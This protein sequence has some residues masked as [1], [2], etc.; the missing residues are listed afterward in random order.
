MKYLK[1]I[2]KAKWIFIPPK[3]NKFVLVDGTYNP[4]LKYLK[5]KDFTI[6]HRR[7]EE[8]NF[9]ILLKCFFKFKF[10]S[11]DYCA[12]FIEY[13]SPKLIL[14]GFDYHTIFYKLSKRTGV[15]TLMLQKGKRSESE[16]IIAKSKKFFPKNSK[17]VFFVDYIF[18]YNKK[19]RDFYS[20]RIGGKYFIIGSFENNFEKLNIYKQKKEIVFISSFRPNNIERSQNENRIA[21]ELFKLAKKNKIPF[22]ILPRFREVAVKPIAYSEELKLEIE[23]YKNFF[24]ENINFLIKSNLSS[25]DILQNYRYVFASASTL[26]IEFL[27]KGGRA[28]FL[29]FK[30]KGNPFFNFGFGTYEGLKKKGL[31]WI[32]DHKFNT[33]EIARVFNN[34]IYTKNSIWIKK[35]SIYSKKI[36]SYEYNNISFKKIINKI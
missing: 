26:A 34:V 3:K 25:Y 35:S 22:K 20:S 12:T 13:V 32:N 1:Y 36:L 24:K 33:K 2:L 30:S 5:K 19:T 17:K 9:F 6:L 8:I 21:L 16:E 15:K 11:L 18:V 10:T 4:F 27:A 14:T 29:T 31:F 23:F 28:G 7:G